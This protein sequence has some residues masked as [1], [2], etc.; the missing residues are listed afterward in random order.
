MSFVHRSAS[1]GAG[2]GQDRAAEGSQES[3]PASAEICAAVKQVDCHRTLCG[4]RS[5]FL[6][7][8]MHR[9]AA[10]QGQGGGEEHVRGCAQLGVALHIR[11]CAARDPSLMTAKSWGLQEHLQEDAKTHSKHTAV[12]KHKPWHSLLCLQAVILQH[13]TPS[14]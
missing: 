13:P 3:A 11:T 14:H 2:P 5:A 8:Q 1:A 6:W 9:A 4:C 7:E 12:T 10:E